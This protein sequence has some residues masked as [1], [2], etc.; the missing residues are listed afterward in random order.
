MQGQWKDVYKRQRVHRKL[1]GFFCL[2]KMKTEVACKER[3]QFMPV[4]TGNVLNLIRM[5]P[6]ISALFL[7]M[8]N[9]VKELLPDSRKGGT[10]QMNEMCIR[11]RSLSANF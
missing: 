11:D 6:A 9:R 5:E 3:Y 4:N 8:M 1:I 10:E 7:E 2:L